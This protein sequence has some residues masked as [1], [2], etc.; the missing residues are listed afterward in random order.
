CARA[1][2]R[3]AVPRRAI[4]RPL[5]AGCAD[6]L[7]TLSGCPRRAALTAACAPIADI[8]NEPWGYGSSF[9]ADAPRARAPIS[10]NA[11]GRMVGGRGELSQSGFTNRPTVQRL[12]SLLHP[13][14]REQLTRCHDATMCD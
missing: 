7:K 9:T 4:V 11:T 3:R 13:D 1:R 10:E 5:R 12:E 2:D 8:A 6:R 14:V